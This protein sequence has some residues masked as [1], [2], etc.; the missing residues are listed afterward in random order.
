MKNISIYESEKIDG[1]YEKISDNLT[2]KAACPVVIDN[3]K[4][5][6]TFKDKVQIPS[7]IANANP[8]Q[9]DL[10]YLYTILVSTGW[11]ANDDIFHHKELWVARNTPQDKPFNLQHQPSLIIGHITDNFALDS[12]LNIIDNSISIDNLPNKYHIATS[13]VIYRQLDQRDKELSKNIS[14]IIGEIEE[15]NKWFVSMECLFTDF[16]YGLID[17]QG[18][19]KIVER[20]NET[21]FLT[22]Y[23]RSYGGKGVYNNC[24]L[25][26]VL[27]NITFSGK[28]LV[29]QPANSDSIIFDKDSFSNF[30]GVAHTL[31]EEIVIST[32]DSDIMTDN[33]EVTVL[34]AEIESLKDRLNKVDEDKVK[35][36]IA[37]IESEKKSLEDAQKDSEKSL[38]ESTAKLDEITKELEKSSSL[39][40]KLETTNKDLEKDLTEANKKLE[41][42]ALEAQKF[43]RISSLVD[44]G[45]DKAK[46]QKTLESFAE[47]SDEQFEKIVELEEAA[48]GNKITDDKEDTQDIEIG[49]GVNK[50]LE[51][52]QED[53]DAE[54][55]QSD[56]QDSDLLSSVASYMGEQLK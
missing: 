35:S 15:G 9:L 48:I 49:E 22:K 37:N 43:E 33:N 38:V 11:N 17:A 34:Q 45:V 12:D 21:S 42:I 13:A 51:N 25:G 8:D 41:D 10:F 44:K 36:Q 46:A 1:L 29:E 30:N 20:N 26:R 27:R 2:I 3:D 6:E 14:V 52:A 7:T 23:I 32:G 39:F 5:V 54:F 19:H 16:D 4:L 53:E 56:D 18:N 47:L 40:K 55:S 50:D 31:K 24:K 28:G